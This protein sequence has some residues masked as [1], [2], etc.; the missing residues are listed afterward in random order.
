MI[1]LCLPICVLMGVVSEAPGSDDT[2]GLSGRVKFMVGIYGPGPGVLGDRG[3]SC[4]SVSESA[5][6]SGACFTGVLPVN[7]L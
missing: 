3:N 5:V 7:L 1:P 4:G 2:R 6:P